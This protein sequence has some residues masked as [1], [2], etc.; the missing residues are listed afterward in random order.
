MEVNALVK[1]DLAESVAVFFEGDVL[2][3][4]GEGGVVGAEED[5]HEADLGDMVMVMVGGGRGGE[6]G[7]QRGEG[8][9]GVVAAEAA[10]EDVEAAGVVVGEAG[11]EGVVAG[12]GDGITE[13]EKLG[14]E[15]C[16]GGG[17]S[18]R[19]GECGW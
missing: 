13:Q 12:L 18:V 11:E 7:V 6:E 19:M 16:R 8:G 10:V 2:G 5:G 17:G 9:G 4:G 3:V 1:G 15:L 14:V